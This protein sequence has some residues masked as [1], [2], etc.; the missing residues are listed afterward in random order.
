MWTT[1]SSVANVKLVSSRAFVSGY[2]NARSNLLHLDRTPW[3]GQN[4]QIEVP[5]TTYSSL[6]NLVG[7]MAD[8]VNVTTGHDGSPNGVDMATHPTAQKLAER[9]LEFLNEVKNL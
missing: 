3:F 5:N 4:A 6:V 8:H 7:N 1:C 2:M 9:S